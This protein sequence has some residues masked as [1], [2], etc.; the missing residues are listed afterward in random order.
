MSKTPAL[1]LVNSHLE[2]ELR[3]R[4]RGVEALGARPRAVEDGVAAV[5][6]H[7]I[8]E[9]LLAFRRVRVLFST[10]CEHLRV[11]SVQT[12]MRE[13]YVLENQRSSDMPASA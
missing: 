2:L 11:E 9:L 12:M 13:G 10:T 5:E 6:R 4:L 3:D 8:L 7:G 1:C